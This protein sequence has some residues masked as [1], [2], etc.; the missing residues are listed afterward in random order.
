MYVLQRLKAE[1]IKHGIRA[2]VG[3]ERAL[4]SMDVKGAGKVNIHQLKQAIRGV[5]LQVP[6]DDVRSLFQHYDW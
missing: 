6:D 3:L 4:R 1:L 5:G 2:I